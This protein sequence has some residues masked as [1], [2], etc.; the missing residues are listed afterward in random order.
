M[1]IPQIWHE[2]QSNNYMTWKLWQVFTLYSKLLCSCQI[3]V[4][5]SMFIQSKYLSLSP[6]PFYLLNLLSVPNWEE[7]PHIHNCSFLYYVAD[8]FL[9]L[10]NPA[11]PTFSCTGVQFKKVWIFNT[12]CGEETSFS[13]FMLT[14]MENVNSEECVLEKFGFL[15]HA[16]WL[17]CTHKVI[18]ND[19]WSLLPACVNCQ[20]YIISPFCSAYAVKPIA[21]AMGAPYTHYSTSESLFGVGWVIS[22]ANLF[23]NVDASQ[24]IS[25]LIWE[26]RVLQILTNGRHSIATYCLH[27]YLVVMMSL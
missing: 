3:H 2:P 5:K 12:I 4:Q 1:Y 15:W 11:V 16:I 8:S 14:W 21:D 17:Q 13:T 10:W 25:N 20:K 18:H 23:I 6:F 24:I 7:D 27:Q 9:N 26:I 22:P 19:L